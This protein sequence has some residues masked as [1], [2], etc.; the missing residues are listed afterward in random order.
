MKT[1][2][3]LINLGLSDAKADEVMLLEERMLDRAVAFQ[4]RKK[5]G[6]IRNAIGTLCRSLMV[7]ADNTMWEPK[8]A[9]KPCPVSVVRFWD[10]DKRDWRCFSV[11]SLIAV[12]GR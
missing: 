3:D 11:G 10:C 5:D 1:K 2:Q 4:F 12:E 6:T 8:G 9:E 7:L